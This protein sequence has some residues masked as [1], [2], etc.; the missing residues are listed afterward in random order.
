MKTVEKISSEIM[1]ITDCRL[2]TLYMAAFTMHTAQ[3]CAPYTS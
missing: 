1:N 2:R 3:I